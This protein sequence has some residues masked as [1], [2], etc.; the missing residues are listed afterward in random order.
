MSILPIP[1]TDILNI[2][3]ENSLVYNTTGQ[4]IKESKE[5]IFNLNGL[6]KGIYHVQ[7]ITDKGKATQKVVVK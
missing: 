2:E 6:A 3:L 5:K 1:T 4:L 7:V